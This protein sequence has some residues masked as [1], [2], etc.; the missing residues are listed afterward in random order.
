M[1]SL[2]ASTRKLLIALAIMIVCSNHCQKSQAQIKKQLET[3]NQPDTV[4]CRNFTDRIS[5]L[6]YHHQF[7]EALSLTEV[8]I[9]KDRNCG[10]AYLQKGHILA[11]LDRPREAIPFLKSGF[12][13]KPKFEEPWAYEAMAQALF[14]NNE[15]QKAIAFLND[16]LTLVTE[17]YVLYNAKGRLEA[18]MQ[19][20]DKAIADLTLSIDQ[21]PNKPG[22][23]YRSRA[24]T[25]MRMKAYEKA[26]AD[27][28]Q[29]IKID[30]NNAFAFSNRARAYKAM[31]NMKE[32]EKDFARSRKLTD[33]ADMPF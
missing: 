30:S 3:P 21:N 22:R 32:A 10:M 25:Y 24:L 27:F 5:T 29:L 15:K 31:G 17:K 18:E 20:F 6:L 13:L 16:G 8:A 2:L 1:P 9:R 26:I 4:S 14:E 23:D 33:N 7:Q 19:Q 11:N 28:S 12:A